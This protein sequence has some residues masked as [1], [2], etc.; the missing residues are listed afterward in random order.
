MYDMGLML[1]P[2]R[3]TSLMGVLHHLTLPPPITRPFQQ[4]STTSIPKSFEEAARYNTT[5]GHDLLARY[6]FKVDLHALK[7]SS[8]IFQGPFG[9]E[10]T[11]TYTTYGSRLILSTSSLELSRP[12]HP[13]IGRAQ[14]PQTSE[15]RDRFSPLMLNSEMISTAFSPQYLLSHASQIFKKRRRSRTK[16]E[17]RHACPHCTKTFNRPSKLRTH[18][19]HP[20]G[21]NP[22][23]CSVSGCG[24][25][26]SSVSNRNSHD[27]RTHGYSRPKRS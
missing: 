26:F 25:R 11:W 13:C 1:T 10:Y 5:C 20:F 23:V 8:Y 6:D 4:S 24:A 19:K 27:R 9:D 18:V 14:I 7:T 3:Q 12:A 15:F 21:V 17:T 22:P 2:E 16:Q